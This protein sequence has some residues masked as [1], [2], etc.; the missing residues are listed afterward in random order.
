L[1]RF[2]LVRSL[3][4]H[5]QALL[6]LAFL[7]DRFGTSRSG[8]HMYLHGLG[9]DGQPRAQRFFLIARSGHGPYIPCMPA[10]LLARK[11][12]QGPL[13]QRGAIPCLGLIDL[14]EYLTALG[15]LDVKVVQEPAGE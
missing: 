8:L 4:P 9:R 10:I 2:G 3:E 15:G 13:T 12:A 7:F 1:V 6:R 11:L 5:A 14:D